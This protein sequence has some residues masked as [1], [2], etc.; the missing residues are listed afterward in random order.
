VKRYAIAVAGM[1]G[2]GKTTLAEAVASELGAALLR[3]DDY[4]RPLDHLTYE[5]R[6]E[7]NFD[8]PDSVDGARMASHL[9]QLLQGQAIEVADYD[10]TRHT[11]GDRVRRIEPSEYVVV[12]GI[13]ALAYEEVIRLC[14]VRAFVDAEESTCLQRRMARDVTER[15]RTPG[16][17]ISRFE[18]HVAP[19]FRRHIL[20]ARSLANVIVSGEEDPTDGKAR[21]LAALPSALPV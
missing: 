19:M 10:F 15:G 4:Y 12:E 1:S 14:D 7:V 18:G 8:H 6:C 16:E 11:S 3:T 17:V 5:E 21:V 9:S 20:P 2:S 13:F